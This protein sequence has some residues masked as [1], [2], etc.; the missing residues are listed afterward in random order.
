M[1]KEINSLAAQDY[2]GSGVRSFVFNLQNHNE[3][4]A[5]DP[6]AMPPADPATPPSGDPPPATPPTDP[7]AEPPKNDKPTG[8]P[9]AYTDFAVPEGFTYDKEAGAEF[10]AVAKELNLSQDQAQK[11]MDLYSKQMTGMQ[12]LQTEQAKAWHEESAKTYKQDEIDLA[13]KTLGRFADKEFIQMLADS[14]LGNHPKMIGVFKSIG[15]QISEGK[16]V[17]APPPPSSGP[18]YANSPGMYK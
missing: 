1:S 2:T 8:A 6:P 10:H 11:L 7:P 17:D 16:F 3:P 15:Q 4:P 9:E 12:E 18:K 5:G 13:N 14:G